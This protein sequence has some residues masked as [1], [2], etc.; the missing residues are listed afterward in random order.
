MLRTTLAAKVKNGYFINKKTNKKAM[1]KSVIINKIKK[2]MPAGIVS[3]ENNDHLNPVLELNDTEVGKVYPFRI[4]NNNGKLEID[5]TDA[6]N[7][8]YAELSAEEFSIEEL[9]KVLMYFESKS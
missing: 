6:W 7:T 2:A 1:K 9:T 5:V 3:I 4:M 8:D